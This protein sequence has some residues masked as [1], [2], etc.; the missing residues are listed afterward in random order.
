M[1]LISSMADN[2]LFL[3]MIT[4]QV[5]SASFPLYDDLY[6][7]VSVVYGADWLLVSGNLLITPN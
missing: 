6:C 7:R 3:V 5:E 2:S 1:A 4:G